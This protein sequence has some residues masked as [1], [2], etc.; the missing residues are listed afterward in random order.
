M[1]VSRVRSVGGRWF[2]TGLLVLVI[3][4][5]CQRQSSTDPQT[6][7]VTATPI[8]IS[9]VPYENELAFNLMYPAD[10]EYQLIQQGL[11]IFGEPKTLSLQAAGASV[12]VFR[13]SPENV[14]GGLEGAFDHY[15]T[16]GPLQAGYNRI[17]EVEPSQLGGR[18]ALKVTVEREA[19]EDQPAMQ[20]YII[21]AQTESGPI[22][23]VSATA[24]QAEWNEHWPGFQIL[25]DSIEFNE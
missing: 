14:R 19:V 25:V 20:A 13:Q 17:N 5:S 23:I 22:Y 18:P 3:G 16:N 10:W 11:L 2:L 4:L 8:R 6:V 1:N 21:S 12:V 7:D 9:V 24:P 15:L